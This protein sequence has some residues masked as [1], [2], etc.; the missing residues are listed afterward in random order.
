MHASGFLLP[1]LKKYFTANE[2][3]FDPGFLI[4]VLSFFG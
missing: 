2:Q 4:P 3:V 1:V